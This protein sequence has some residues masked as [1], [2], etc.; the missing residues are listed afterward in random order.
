MPLLSGL[1]ARAHCS[2][3][4]VGISREK[5]MSVIVV[6]EQNPS[7]PESFQ[8]QLRRFDPDLYVTWH[9]SPHSKQPGRWKIERC[10]RHRPD[11]G[12]HNH[13][14]VRVYI[15]MVQDEQGTPLPLGEHVFTKLREM[16]A[17]WEA[18]GGDTERG[19]RNALSFSNAIEQ[20]LEEK[21]EAERQDM[22]AHNR[23]FNGA[24]F[25]KL[26]DLVSRHDMRPNR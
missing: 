10:T 1:S 5:F 15:W 25:Q 24:Q 12:L 17:N 2:D 23:R 20:G 16:R 9:K 4:V 18:F 3:L 8:A 11:G 26:Y 22:I 6:G 19:L 13:L 14:C 7:I 21:R